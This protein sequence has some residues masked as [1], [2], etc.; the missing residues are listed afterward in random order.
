[1]SAIKAYNHRGLIFMRLICRHIIQFGLLRN[2]MMVSKSFLTNIKDI[3]KKKKYATSEKKVFLEGAYK[4]MIFTNASI[5]NG[6]V[7]NLDSQKLERKIY[8]G[9]K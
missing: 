9:M 2:S 4:L 5:I 8:E 1:M 3:L 7:V 6:K